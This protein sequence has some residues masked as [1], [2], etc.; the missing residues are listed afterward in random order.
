VVG[1]VAR[2]LEGGRHGHLEASQRLDEAIVLGPGVRYCQS[3]ST[4][5]TRQ[6]N[7]DVVARLRHVDSYTGASDCVGSRKVMVGLL[8]S[9]DCGPALTAC[10]CNE[11]RSRSGP[12]SE[13]VPTCYGPEFVAAAVRGLDRRRPRQ[14]RLHRAGEPMGERLLRD[15]Q[16]Q[17]AR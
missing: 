14:G 6:L 15:L 3:S 2:R 4:R 5:R 10:R 1:I 17:A 11:R 7:Q 13:Q 8:Q 12:P 16:R 9:G